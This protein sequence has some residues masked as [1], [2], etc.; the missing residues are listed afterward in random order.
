MDSRLDSR[1]TA[2]GSIFKELGIHPFLQNGTSLQGLNQQTCFSCAGAD[3]GLTAAPLPNWWQY[4]DW[5][6]ASGG[7]GIEEEEEGGLCL[8][9]FSANCS[10]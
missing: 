7:G 10:G 5:H 2:A 4:G 3:L 8:C 6:T 1:E 9:A